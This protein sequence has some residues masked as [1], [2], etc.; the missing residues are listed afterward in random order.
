M[1]RGT[2]LRLVAAMFV[3]GALFLSSGVS[4]RTFQMPVRVSL[5]AQHP[6]NAVTVGHKK[7]KHKKHKNVI[8]AGE[9][10]FASNM[11]TV[12]SFKS[13]VTNTSLYLFGTVVCAALKGGT[14]LPAE[15]PS[16]QQDWTNTTTGD[17]IQMITL[18]ARDMCPAESAPQTVTYVVTG[19]SADVTYGPAGSDDQGNVPMSVSQPLSDP[20][21]YSISAQLNG[22]G[23]VSCALEV[24]GVSISTASAS[25]GY[26]IA[27]CEIDQ[28][29]N[30][31]WEN[32][33]DG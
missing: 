7:K 31:S 33:N 3:A 2:S 17:A 24:D 8:T 19:D 20:S 23:T 15:V 30:G 14:A 21:Y 32:T 18:A 28:A 11:R 27:S 22:Y 12:F 9:R 25:G 4:A 6:T 5:Q 29:L 16:V 10:R 1:L 26:N 13:S